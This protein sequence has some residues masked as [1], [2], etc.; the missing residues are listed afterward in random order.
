MCNRVTGD[1]P[2]Y[3]LIFVIFPYTLVFLGTLIN[4]AIIYV[5]VQRLIRTRDES[6][7]KSAAAAPPSE[8][9]HLERLVVVRTQSFLYV[10]ILIIPFIPTFILRG[11]QSVGFGVDDVD[12][13]FFV[14]AL[15]RL[16]LPIQGFLNCLIYIR[17]TYLKARRD[18]PSESRLWVWQRAL[19]GDKIQPTDE[20]FVDE[21]FVVDDTGVVVPTSKPQDENDHEQVT[22]TS[23]NDRAPMMPKKEAM[24]DESYNGVETCVGSED[25]MSKGYELPVKRSVALLEGCFVSSLHDKSAAELVPSKQEIPNTTTKDTCFRL[26]NQSFIEAMERENQYIHSNNNSRTNFPS[27]IEHETNVNLGSRSSVS[28]VT[29]HIREVIPKYPSLGDLLEDD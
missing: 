13:L 15:Q 18:F 17:P 3:A 2:L 23:R 27:R 16:I 20:P 29:C 14:M 7:R 19:H 24:H 28:S 6:L 22:S 11:F 26:P 8:D 12:K 21:P 1:E 5:H 25:R 9:P 4:N 10:G